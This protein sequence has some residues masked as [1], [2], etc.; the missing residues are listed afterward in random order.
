LEEDEM[1]LTVSDEGMKTLHVCS[2]ISIEA[3][4]G[5]KRGHSL[6]ILPRERPTHYML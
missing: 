2:F 6:S 4:D 1:R 3:E 5:E